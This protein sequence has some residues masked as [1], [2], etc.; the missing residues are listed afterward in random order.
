M[1]FCVLNDP[2]N[3]KANANDERMLKQCLEK[4]KRPENLFPGPKE[5]GVKFGRMVNGREKTKY[6]RVTQSL[7]W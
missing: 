2:D 5:Y 1:H 7:T 6:V 4:K 3:I